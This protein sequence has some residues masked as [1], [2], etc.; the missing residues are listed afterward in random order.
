M[1]VS[2]RLD[3]PARWTR[4]RCALLLVSAIFGFFLLA[5]GAWSTIGAASVGAVGALV[6][7]LL[8]RSRAARRHHP[9][10]EVAP[11]PALNG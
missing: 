3:G 8:T 7:E 1:L 9:A 6:A 2:I 4:V 11:E 5:H 10:P